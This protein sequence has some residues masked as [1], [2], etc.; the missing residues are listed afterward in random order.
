MRW[1]Q[2][3]VHRKWTY[4]GKHKGGRTRI[5]K[6]FDTLFETEG[7]H[8]IHMPYLV[9]NANAYAERWVRNAREEYLDLILS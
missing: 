1:H 5:S 8:V 3:L 9:P 6:A 7:L 4:H 2:E